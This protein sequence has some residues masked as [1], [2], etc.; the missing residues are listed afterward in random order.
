MCCLGST[1]TTCSVLQQGQLLPLQASGA[2]RESFIDSDTVLD[3]C[4]YHQ[5]QGVAE[6]IKSV[7]RMVMSMM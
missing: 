4:P 7:M 1:S 6:R 2:I 5:Q 3:N